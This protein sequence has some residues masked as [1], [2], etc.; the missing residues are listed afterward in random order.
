[1]HFEKG[2]CFRSL[3]DRGKAGLERLSNIKLKIDTA[4][5]KNKEVTD[6]DYVSVYDEDKNWTVRQYTV[7]MTVSAVVSNL[8]LKL[9]NEIETERWRVKEKI[10]E[11]ELVLV[12][13]YRLI[14]SLYLL[15]QARSS[16]W[17]VSRPDVSDIES[18]VSHLKSTISK[19]INLRQT[20]RNDIL[21][22]EFSLKS[23]GKDI[24]IN[25][26]P[27]AIIAI[28]SVAS[29]LSAIGNSIVRV[30]K[31]VR[32]LNELTEKHSNEISEIVKDSKVRVQD[33]INKANYLWI[34]CDEGLRAL[35]ELCLK[36]KPLR[37]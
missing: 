11:S 37:E 16:Y 27:E 1:M 17:V 6:K 21:G 3:L 32:V 31:Y 8:N 35:F 10:S 25:I 9:A 34:W 12:K 33:L 14:D 20:I 13:T 23:D 19:A 7:F 4:P 28:T 2:T 30:R 15:E 26:W 24:D 36:L 5:Y 22:L 29:N 18:L